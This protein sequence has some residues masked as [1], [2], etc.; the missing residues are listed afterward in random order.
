MNRLDIREAQPDDVVGIIALVRAAY[1][2]Y[3]ARIG[4]EPAP[5]QADYAALVDQGVV[6]VLPGDGRLRAVLVMMPEGDHLFVENIAVHP[7][8]QGRGLG[9]LLM[10]AADDRA[11]VLG[12]GAV[13]LY[14]NEAMTENLA[15]Y[16]R[17]GFVEVERRLDDGFRRVFMRKTLS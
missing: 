6:Y 16:P 10:A 17:L 14:T 3:V 12:L 15:F 9:R 7:D 4:R 5:M 13:E 1:A 8:E 11:R 2:P